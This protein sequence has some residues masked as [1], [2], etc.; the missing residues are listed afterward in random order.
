MQNNGLKFV[1]LAGLASWTAHVGYSGEAGLFINPRYTPLILGTAWILAFFTLLQFY[2]LLRDTKAAGYLV[3]RA[4]LEYRRW[5][6]EALAS[7][8]LRYRPAHLRQ[9]VSG[10]VAYGL[11]TIP[12]IFGFLPGSNVLTGEFAVQK[13]LR[14]P[15]EQG[16]SS[17]STGSPKLNTKLNGVEGTFFKPKDTMRVLPGVEIPKVS[18]AKKNESKKPEPVVFDEKNFL[19]LL[20]DIT[21]NPGGYEGRPVEI[22]GFLFAPTKA[23]KNN[24]YIARYVVSCC[25]ADAVL[26]GMAVENTGKTEIGA[27]VR[28]K[29]TFVSSKCPDTPGGLT[30]KVKEIKPEPQPK[31]P[32]IYVD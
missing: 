2:R 23:D 13:G 20:I 1:L 30:I 4:G 10:V 3:D 8:R 12:V 32:Y 18:N 28:A 29:G 9:W 14:L 22:S 31:N 5:R 24:L 17:Q 21:E 27:W 16:V 26:T 19:G 25:V 7:G 15:Q 11:F 6:G